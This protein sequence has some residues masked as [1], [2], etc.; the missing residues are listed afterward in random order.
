M[1][2]AKKNSNAKKNKKKQQKKNNTQLTNVQNKKHIAAQIDSAHPITEKS[3]AE[4]EQMQEVSAKQELSVRTNVRKPFVPTLTLHISHK[5]TTKTLSLKRSHGIVIAAALT[6]AVGGGIIATA[7]YFHTQTQLQ[8]SMHQLEEMEKANRILT[9]QAAKLEDENTKYNESLD[10]IQKKTLQ[11]E[12]KMT[13][14]ETTKQNLADELN[15]MTDA[16]TADAGAYLSILNE[17]PTDSSAFTNVVTTSYNKTDSL[18]NQLE[19]LDVQLDETGISFGNIAEN[20]TVSLAA[21]SNIPQ[22]L[23][24]GGVITTE[25]NP[26]GDPSISDGRVH[27][28][29]D[30]STRRQV[31]PIAATAAGTVITS[32]FHSGYGNYICIDHGNGFVT[33][34]AHNSENLVSVGDKVKK[35]DT[36]AMSGSTGMSTGIHCHYEIH[37]NGAYQNPRDFM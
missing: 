10:E 19:K 24:V 20:V 28:G 7:S 22:G 2:M 35:G 8:S 29:M 30:I 21:Q 37:L 23:P 1:I 9:N 27:K 16:D 34:Y 14:L 3:I 33:L 12:N 25:F 6:L 31:V 26:N 11:L 13:E 17:T 4:K 18:H 5:D 15:N 36:I 32:Q